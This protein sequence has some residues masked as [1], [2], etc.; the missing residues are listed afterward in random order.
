M[1]PEELKR[2][3]SVISEDTIHDSF[4]FYQVAMLLA[5]IVNEGVVA[6]Q[7]ICAVL[8]EPNPEEVIRRDKE[9]SDVVQLQAEAL[10]AG[11]DPNATLYDDPDATLDERSPVNQP[12][13]P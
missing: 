4:P 11:V 13:K 7:G 1:K 2:R 5:E 9:A 10:G 12:R 8:T 3:V 6:L